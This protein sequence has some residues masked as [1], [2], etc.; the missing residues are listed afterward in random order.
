MKNYHNLMSPSI[1][2]PSI[3]QGRTF[4]THKNF[5]YSQESVEE[6]AKKK[7]FFFISYTPI[8]SQMSE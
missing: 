2:R 1:T 4:T 5:S 7:N 3:K 6:E 8:H